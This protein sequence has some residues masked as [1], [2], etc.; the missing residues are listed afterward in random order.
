MK[1]LAAVVL[2]TGLIIG[3]GALVFGADRGEDKAFT[4][5]QRA[6]FKQAWGQFMTQ[7]QDQRTQLAGKVEQ[8]KI[9]YA[10]P[11]PDRAKI[12]ALQNEI[13]DLR[14]AIAKNAVTWQMGLSDDLYGRCGERV[15]HMMGGGRDHKWHDDENGR[16]R[17]RDEG[18]P[19]DGGRP[20]N[21]GPQRGAPGR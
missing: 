19:R 14:A 4:Q 8:L 20:R 18:R 21:E 12:A 15:M 1:K 11:A 7:T 17:H 16:G 9:L 2:I 10:Q 13:I 5:E 6:Q 3:T